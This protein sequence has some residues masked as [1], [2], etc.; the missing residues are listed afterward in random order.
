MRKRFIPLVV[1]FGV[2]VGALTQAPFGSAGPAAHSANLERRVAQLERK[3]RL[4]AQF[5]VLTIARLGR[6]E[7]RKLVVSGGVG[8][9]TN[10]SSGS[11]GTIT[12]S[13]CIG[14][15]DVPV[16][17]SY[18]TD[19]P[20]MPGTISRSFSTWRMAA[21]VQAG[22]HAAFVRAEPVCVTWGY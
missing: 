21:Y 8:S 3:M 6:L 1:I 11:W 10:I 14:P 18:T 12:T 15:N 13:G 7:S 2:G 4:Q 19:Y 5:N 16:G 22:W 20:I 9:S 17:L